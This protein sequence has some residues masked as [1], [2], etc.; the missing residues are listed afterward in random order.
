MYSRFVAAGRFVTRV[1]A[2]LGFAYIAE[3]AV[4]WH[5]DNPAH[6]SLYLI[7]GLAA[8]AFMQW[9]H[10][11]K[12]G[13]SVNLFLVPLGVVELGLPETIVLSMIGPVMSAIAPSSGKD[14]KGAAISLANEATAAAAASFAYHSLVPGP[15]SAAAIRLFLGSGVYFA[16]RTFPEAV[17]VATSRGRR[18]GRT[19]KEDHFWSFPYY[20]AGASAAGFLSIRNTFLHWEVCLLTAPVLYLLYRAHKAREADLALLQQRTREMEAA[21]IAAEEASRA[22]SEF[23]ANISHEIRTPMNGIL[24]LTDVALESDLPPELRD[25]LETVKGCA[26][27]LLALLNEVLDFAKIEAGKLE[28]SPVPFHLREFIEKICHPFAHAAAS[29]RVELQWHISPDVEDAI[30]GDPVRL[31]QVLTNLLGN[32]LKFTPRGEVKLGVSVQSRYANLVLL[33]FIVADTGIGVPLSKQRDIFEA[34]TQAD[35]SMT[36]KYGGTGL[37]LAI[38]SRLAEKMGGRIWVESEPGLGSAFHFTCALELQDTLLDS[39]ETAGIQHIQH[40]P[41]LALQSS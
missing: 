29:K 34:F 11:G 5:S 8:A 1:I 6:F 13:V 16:T 27:S 36:R 7:T 15:S 37:G 33:H 30:A 22:K 3:I 9:K 40:M 41:P 21:K 19:W 23:L 25:S 26:D 35:G 39:D 20:L 10:P 38:C 28:L 32:A 2:A 12:S 14:L 31:G 4:F 24:G 17:R 18:L